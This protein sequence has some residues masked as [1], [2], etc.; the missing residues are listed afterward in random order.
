[1]LFSSE[2]EKINTLD[3]SNLTNKKQQQLI[4]S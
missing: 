3:V 4:H 1:M 2:N